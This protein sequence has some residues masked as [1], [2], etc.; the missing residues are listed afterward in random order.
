MNKK[1]G[2]RFGLSAIKGMGTGAAMAIV[3]KEIRMDRIKTYSTLLN[4]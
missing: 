4:V 3:A 2:I 1:G